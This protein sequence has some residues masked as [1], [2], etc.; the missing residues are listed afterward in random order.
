MRGYGK[1]GVTSYFFLTLPLLI[2]IMRVIFRIIGLFPILVMVSS[3]STG[4]CYDDIDPLLNVGLFADGTE[5]ARKADS[6]VIIGENFDNDTILVDEKSVSS[7]S[8]MLNP[9]SQSVTLYIYLNDMLDTAVINYDSYPH[10]VSSEC[11]YTL[12]NTITS[13]T[14]THHIID[15]LNIENENV[16]LDGKRNLRL[17]Y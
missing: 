17:F 3:C 7:F 6:L 4:A 13:L 16:T 2:M 9:A 10:M 15:S 14:T 11:G 12:F 8:L 5:V 1:Q